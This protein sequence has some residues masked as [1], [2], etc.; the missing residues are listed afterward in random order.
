MNS[1]WYTLLKRRLIVLILLAFSTL[2][3]FIFSLGHKPASAHVA[4]TTYTYLPIISYNPLPEP[5]QFFAN[6]SLPG[7]LCPNDIAVNE[8]SGIVYVANSYSNDVSILQNDA[9]VHN[10]TIGKLP[11]D[12]APIPNSD[13]TYITHLTDTAGVNQIAIFDKTALVTRAPDYFEP[14]DIIY[15]PVNGY[16]YVTDLNSAVRVINGTSV[17][18]DVLLSGAGWIRSIEVDPLTGLVYA[19]S[20]EKGIVYVIDGTTLINQFQA[21]WGTMEIAL[22]PNSGYFYLAH[23]DPNQTYT[24]NISVF[25]RNNYTVTPIYT[26]DKSIDV[27]TDPIFGLAYA[28]NNKNNTV[29]VLSGRSVVRTVSV[30]DNPRAVT[31]DP[32]TGYAFVGNH[33]SNTVTIFRNGEVISTQEAGRQPYA[34]AVN[35]QTNEVYVANRTWRI[36]CDDLGRCDPKCDDYTATVTILR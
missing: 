2:T 18:A 7:A 34:I 35:S 33:D 30:G 20:W 12:I 10:V 27:A 11:T 21:G 19:A 32:S 29:T 36:V 15:N 23:S 13:R 4:D 28:T 9:F 3:F 31:V 8:H 6:V 22:E 5:P 17:V 25:H 24:Q 26:G 16:V 14:H 1:I